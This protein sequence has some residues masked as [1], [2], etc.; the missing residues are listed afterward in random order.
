MSHTTLSVCPSCPLP[1]ITLTSPSLSLRHPVL[2]DSGSDASLMDQEL[3]KRLGLDSFLLPKHLDASALDE[4]LSCMVT[5]H[6]HP[7]Q[8]TFLMVT[9]NPL[10][11]ICF[12]PLS[13]HSV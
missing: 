7:L 5:L 4:C 3:A 1:Y 8:V 6:T 12:S 13:I 10:V 2:V 9:L 11:S